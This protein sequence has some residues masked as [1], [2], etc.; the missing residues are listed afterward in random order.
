MTMHAKTDSDG[1]L[2]WFAGSLATIKVSGEAGADTISVIEHLMPYGSSPPLHIHV[3]EDE[4]FHILDG[5]MRFNVGGK[6]FF[7]RA[8]QTMMAPKG[9]P[10]SYRVES[11]EGA[12]C[13]TVT[14]RG[15]FERLVREIGVPTDKAEFP[16]EVAPTPEAIKA[17]TEA[18]A[19]N[20]I[21]IIGAP[22]S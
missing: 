17:L 21:D 22:L 7:G 16:L 20:G 11:A 14:T 3:N 19:R 2:L 12:R 6:E 15:D 10:H 5:V 9:V 18:C 13:L 1:E 8:G 4:V